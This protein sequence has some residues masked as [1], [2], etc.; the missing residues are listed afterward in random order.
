[1]KASTFILII[2]VP[3]LLLVIGMDLYYSRGMMVSS[4]IIGDLVWFTVI[5]A[6]L[7]FLA[8]RNEREM[9]ERT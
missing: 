4:S 7:Y 3:C 6:C 8:K 5:P 2:S 1:M 9:G